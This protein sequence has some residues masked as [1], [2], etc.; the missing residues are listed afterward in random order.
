[1]TNDLLYQVALTCVPHIGSVQAR[2]LL[3]QYGSAQAV[4][5]ARKKELEKAAGIGP[6]RAAS[7]KSFDQF[8]R[9][10][11]EIAFLEKFRITPLEINSEAYPKRLRHCYDAPL[12]LYYRGNADLN[13]ERVISVVGTRNHTDYGKMICEQLIAELAGEN[14]LILSGLALGIDT[15]AHRAA[16]RHG[17][18]TVGVLAHGLDRIYPRSNRGLARQ[19][20]EAGGLLTEF[21]SETNPDKPNFPRRNRIVA[22]MCDLVLV[23]ETGIRGGSLITAELGNNYH[24]DVLAVPGRLNDP[25]SEGCNYLIRTHKA[26]LVSGAADLLELMNWQPAKKRAA[27]QRSLF[28]E[29]SAEEKI[30]TEIL[31]QQPGCGIDELYLRSGLSSSAAAAA[32]L[33]LEMQGLVQS[34]PGKLFRLT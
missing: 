8:S 2:L 4:F 17:L 1:M 9:C 32:L 16:L 20:T 34:L 31:Q 10:E 14:I 18:P 7:I 11:A 23:I 27:T 12:L 25:R 30:I 6:V 13:A 28:I 26:G 15:L 5:R 21:P 24:R 33:N 22:G 3:Q 29:L 19:M